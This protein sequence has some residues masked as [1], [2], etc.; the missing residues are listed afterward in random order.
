MFVLALRD[1]MVDV[2][3]DDLADGAVKTLC[4]L[5]A[6]WCS[7]SISEAHI[8]WGASI[9]RRCMALVPPPGLKIEI[10]VTNFKTLPSNQLLLLMPGPTH[11]R[12]TTEEN[13]FLLQTRPT[14]SRQTTEDSDFLLPPTP[15][16]ARGRG[17][18]KQSVSRSSSVGSTGSTDSLIDRSPV[19]PSFGDEEI[20]VTALGTRENYTLDL[21]NF[22]G[23]NDTALPGEEVLSQ[24]VIK[25]GKVRR[26]KTRKLEKLKKKGTLPPGNP[27][28][29][30]FTEEIDLATPNA[31]VTD[32][33]LPST[34]SQTPSII[35]HSRP[36]SFSEY[37]DPYS[38]PSSMHS[39][40]DSE[41]DVASLRSLMPQ[42][43]KGSHGEQI[44]LEV[45]EQEMKDINVVSEHARPGKPKLDRILFDEV[46]RATGSIIVGCCG[47]SSLNA[48]IRKSIA[49]QIDPTRIKNGEM[50]GHITLVSEE[51]SY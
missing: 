43:G 41:S 51:F 19:T 8:Q 32:L 33:Q 30:R 18:H 47:P 29:S 35:S 15:N 4:F 20:D 2:W 25:A 3:E 28:D 42:V 14:H 23:D 21:T 12:Q 17:S 24:K 50:Q 46:E 45:P 5:I 36:Q 27:R 31:S 9:L 16:F 39:K 37:S 40:F 34:Q 11:S 6:G 1:V 44:R 7:D 22:D 49:A 38:R 10:F 26:A 48:M 13:E